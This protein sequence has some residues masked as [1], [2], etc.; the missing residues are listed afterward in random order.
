MISLDYSK[1]SDY[2]FKMFWL[3]NNSDKGKEKITDEEWDLLKKRK[4]DSDK[5]EEL[6][7]ERITDEDLSI[8]DE[9]DKKAAYIYTLMN[10]GYS[11]DEKDI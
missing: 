7:M 2:N 6:K 1:L 9:R 3:K 8:Y 10:T 4:I 5:I 11:Y